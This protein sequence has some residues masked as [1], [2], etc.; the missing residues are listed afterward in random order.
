[1]TLF[2]LVIV[3]VIIA[4][5]AALTMPNLTAGARQREVRQTMQ[6]FVSAVR[7]SSSVAV[8]TRSPVE[9]R[10][11]VEEKRYR[12]VIPKS[13]EELAEEEEEGRKNTVRRLGTGSAANSEE[14]EIDGEVRLEV[15]L[16][17]AAEFGELEGGGILF[18][19]DMLIQFH[20]NGSSSGGV[21]EVVFNAGERSEQAY[22]LRINPLT[23]AISFAD[24]DDS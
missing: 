23:S 12:I 6:Q 5:A 4:V 10:I 24:E 13:E 19:E 20:P 21:V 11:D 8:F 15:V 1:M 16:P 22:K 2:E 17:E 18:D 3:V 9:M 7:R 14:S